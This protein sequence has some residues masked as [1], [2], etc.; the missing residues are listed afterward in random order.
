MANSLE[1]PKYDVLKSYDEVEVRYYHP[2][3]QARVPLASNNKS[4]NGF[5]TLAGFIFGDNIGNNAISMTAPVQEDIYTDKP[6]MAFTM[7]SQ[8]SLETLPVPNNA[9]VEI[10]SLPARVVAVIPFSGW[11]T[12]GKVKR[13]TNQLQQTLETV[14][15]D[16]LSNPKLNQYNPPWTLPVFRRN[17]IMIEIQWGTEHHLTS[18]RR[19]TIDTSL[20]AQ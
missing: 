6:T 1:E 4:A 13:Y 11:A 17:E 2:V 16:T 9:N 10:I 20:A 3:I 15:L 8:Y 7:P 18:D 19:S 12:D 14:K 5:K